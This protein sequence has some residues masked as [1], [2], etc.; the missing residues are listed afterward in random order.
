MNADEKMLGDVGTVTVTT[1]KTS[2]PL[3]K[4]GIG[5]LCRQWVKCGAGGCRC[6]RGE[7]HGPYWYLLWWEHGR[8]RKRYVPPAE[9]DAIRA[10]ILARRERERAR[11]E[12]HRHFVEMWRKA[13]AYLR[14]VERDG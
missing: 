8:T 10:A 4:A 12:K 1:V 5:A 13:K 7:L 3:P 6:A 14:E 2:R 9:L 11:R